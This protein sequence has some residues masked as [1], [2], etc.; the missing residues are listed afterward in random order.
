[1]T[2]LH[3]PNR[4]EHDAYAAAY[5]DGILDT[6]FGLSLL[7]I[8]AAWLWLPDIS[9]LAGVLPAILIAPVIALQKRVVGDR[10]GHVVWS[11]T[12]RCRE[13]IGAIA[14][15]ALGAVVLALGI[16]VYF[17]VAQQGSDTSLIETLIP[18]LPALLLAFGAAAV[19]LTTGIRRPFIYAVVLAA[20]G[21]LTILG[22]GDPGVDLFVSGC[23][24][25]IIGATMLT[26]FLRR[27]PRRSRDE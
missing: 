10:L 13:R 22:D 11:G 4:L 27:Y 15:V 19:A 17:A 20:S 16:G 14:L 26:T 7:W 23:I 6:F 1:V 3:D 2:E 21:L 8:G 9:G 24:I 18:G 12:R 5:S 25:T